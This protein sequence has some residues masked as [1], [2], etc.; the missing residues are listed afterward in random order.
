MIRLISYKQELRILRQENDKNYRLRNEFQ[1]F[2]DQNILNAV[3]EVVSILICPVCGKRASLSKIENKFNTKKC[4]YCGDESYD[5]ELYDNIGEK[6]RISNK[7]L[8]EI[9]L[10]IT[11]TDEELSNIHR[12]L[13]EL[14]IQLDNL[15]L[16]LNPKIVRSVGNFNSIDDEKL[17]AYINEQRIELDR[18][19]ANLNKEKEDIRKTN[20]LIDDKTKLIEA[21]MSNIK[22][23]ENQIEQMYKELE[24]NS[25]NKFLDKLNYYYEKLMGY[26]KQPIYFENGYLCFKVRAPGGRYDVEYISES[27]DIGESEK[28][29]IDAAL[30]FTFVDL[31]N[32]NNASLLNFVIMD[33][34]ADS[35]IDNVDLPLEAHNRANLLSLIKEKCDLDNSQYL[36]L[37][38]D[39]TYNDVLELPMKSITFNKDLSRYFA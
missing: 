4:P 17:K 25:I 30:V 35:L 21:L 34:P 14:N 22:E 11:K 26:K 3:K 19:L 9:D 33:D 31:D 23:Q 6:I 37:T 39:V 20:E 13:E 8:P 32:E 16:I 15:K 7:Q 28:R 27:T 36:I 29:C 1:K 38:A 5:N 2:N 10:K 18:I 12:T 24:K